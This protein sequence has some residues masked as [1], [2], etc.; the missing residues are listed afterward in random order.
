VASDPLLVEV[1]VEVRGGMVGA[2]WEE[3][4]RPVWSPTVVVGAVLGESE[5]VL[6]RAAR[7]IGRTGV[8]LMGRTSACCKKSSQPR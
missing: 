5:A 4:L 6:C 1:E 3:S 8:K 7:R 2:W